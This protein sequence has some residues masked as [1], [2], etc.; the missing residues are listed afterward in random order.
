MPSVAAPSPDTDKDKAADS[1]IRA[2]NE[3]DARDAD[4]I[5]APV[6]LFGEAYDANNERVEEI[7]AGDKRPASPRKASASVAAWS[8]LKKKS[9]TSLSPMCLDINKVDCVATAA[10]LV[11]Y[12]GNAT[13]NADN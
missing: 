9:N 7:A 12:G 4:D 8:P 1:A 13:P 2:V 5:A 3:H 11:I 10:A 6:R